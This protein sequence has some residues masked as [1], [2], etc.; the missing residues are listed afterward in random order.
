MIEICPARFPAD[1]SIARRLFRE[2]ADSL[3][4]DLCFQDFDTELAN[5]PGK[6]A[7][8]H[9]QLLLA[10]D[11]DRA[12]GCVALRRIDRDTCEMKRLYIQPQ[13]RAQQL[14]RRL[15][16]KICQQARDAGYQRICLDTLATMRPA[17]RL[18]GVLGFQAIE[19]YVFNPIDGAIFLGLD[20]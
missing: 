3:D 6:Y 10:W 8:P 11:G 20:L 19:P 5:L 2:Y 12:V 9:G 18:Y 15:A 1:L 17:L 16:E 13:A 14:G 7:E 4:I